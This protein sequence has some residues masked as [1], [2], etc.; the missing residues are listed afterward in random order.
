MLPSACW[1]ANH[2]AFANMY[3]TI[4]K[5]IVRSMMISAAD[6]F[7]KDKIT[8]FHGSSSEV[9]KPTYGVGN[10]RNDYGLAFYCTELNELACEWACPTEADGVV[11]EYELDCT[12]LKLLD[13]N[14]EDYSVLHWL[15][16]LVK[17]RPLGQRHQITSEMQN[18][19]VK[20]YD[21][22][23]SNADIIYGY[24]ADDS[25]FSFA[26]LFLNNT[27]SVESLEQALFLG[28]LGYQVAL[29]SKKAFKHIRF[30]GSEAVRG[31]LWNPRRME[32]DSQARKAFERIQREQGLGGTRAIDI[33][34][35]AE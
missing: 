2:Y 14:S 26:R 11:N 8:I 21:V 31:A 32:R 28:G 17:N 19:L 18:L 9:N 12:G 3:Y 10:P 20:Q 1:T 15:A 5:V 33:I 23:L 22:D 7:G 16:V 34:R 30:V 29:R 6:F 27:I 13:L 24:R 25:Y 4:T 35:K